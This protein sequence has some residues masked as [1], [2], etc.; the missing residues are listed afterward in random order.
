MSSPPKHPPAEIVGGRRVPPHKQRA[1]PAQSTA[2]TAVDAVLGSSSNA[3]DGDEVI[4]QPQDQPDVTAKDVA[5]NPKA[6][7]ASFH[8]PPQ[9]QPKHPSANQKGSMQIKQPS[10]RR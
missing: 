3:P 2:V 6:A 7:P 1:A 4:P 8:P 5:A 9:K 10:G